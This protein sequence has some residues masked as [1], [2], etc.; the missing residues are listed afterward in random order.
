M[1]AAFLGNDTAC[2]TLL[3]SKADFRVDTVYGGALES[4]E[5]GGNP[6]IVKR[7][8]D[9]GAVFSTTRSD[10]TN[11]V[12]LAAEAGHTEVLK[13][14]IDRKAA[15]D[16]AD[17]MGMTALMHACRRGQIGTT[18]LLLAAGAEVNVGDIFGRTPLMYA[19]LNGHT[20]EVNRLLGKGAAVNVKDKNGDTALILS[21]RYSG[22][23][24]IAGLLKAKGAVLA[25]RDSRNRTAGDIARARGYSAFA[26]VVAP[27]LK[28]APDIR[29]SAVPD[30][31]RQAVQ[32]SLPLIE[33]TTAKFTG[34]IGCNSC[35]HQGV[36]LMTTGTAKLHGYLIDK[37]A[38]AKEQRAVLGE[39]ER[40]MDGIREVL[41]HQEQYKHLPAVDMEE[42]SPA[43]GVSHAALAQHGVPAS[44]A[45]TAMTTI[46]ARQQRVDG[47]WGFAVERAPIQSSHFSTTAY[48]IRTLNAYLP[49]SLATEKKTRVAKAREWLIRTPAKNNEDRAFRLLALKWAD[50]PQTEIA[51][52]RAE[53]L[54]F[55]R[56]DGG[57][58]QF[59]LA[60]AAPGYSRSDAYA[61][62]QSLYALHVGGSVQ[63]TA[64]AYRRGVEYL[65]RTQDE[66]GSWFV[67]KRA[68]PMN[69][70]LDTGFPHGVSQ[71]ISYTGTCWATMSLIFAAE[72][73]KNPKP[74]A[75]R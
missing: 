40:H 43:V 17:A 60:G 14:L 26:G 66:D 20:G 22:D 57:W 33:K 50:A 61:T 63:A 45:T 11:I 47:S 64:T 30:K 39:T 59:S 44:E 23:V 1:W 75:S 6:R 48:A 28:P 73:A 25:A 16:E 54:S 69:N 24:Q 35:H 72:P 13:M 9:A 31:A 15:I 67:N 34:T 29:P 55:Q 12:I 10:K 74:L 58:G 8:L 4:A 18:E 68:I 21:A 53:I 49:A 71:Y 65:L 56:K 51:A 42:F 27:G 52:A 7:L 38:V 19:A 2:A 70:Y 37:F 36:G 62:G 5:M 32:R 46:L 41:P 3:E